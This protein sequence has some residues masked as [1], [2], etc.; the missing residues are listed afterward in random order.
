LKKNTTNNEKKKQLIRLHLQK[1]KT[2][3]YSLDSEEKSHKRYSSPDLPICD[4]NNIYPCKYQN[5]VFYNSDE[6]E[7][8]MELKKKRNVSTGY[9]SRTSH[10]SEMNEYLKKTGSV[11][12]KIPKENRLHDPYTGKIYD[13]T[14]LRFG[15]KLLVNY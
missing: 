15:D 12:K 10:Y 9:K 7:E 1:N 2:K 14:T 13:K 6:Y 3:S 11:G 5:T 4:D 8:Y